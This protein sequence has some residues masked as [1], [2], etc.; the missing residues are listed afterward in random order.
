MLRPQDITCVI[1]D[2]GKTLSMVST[3]SGTYN[4]STGAT[5]STTATTTAVKGMFYSYN[6]M[7]RNGS[8]IQAGDR[9]LAIPA[10]DTSGDATPVPK[11]GDKVSGEGDTVSVVSVSKVLQ[12][13]S[14]V[15]Y[16]CQV[17]E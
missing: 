9:K 13:A 3:S 7:E 12:G 4:P 15:C 17:R 11:V 1:N 5:G 2:F 14:T 16:I 10:T 8:A 6:S